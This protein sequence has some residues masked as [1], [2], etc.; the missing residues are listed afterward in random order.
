MLKDV[1]VEFFL[2]FSHLLKHH[3]SEYVISIQGIFERFFTG[4]HFMP[5]RQEPCVNGD[6]RPI[7]EETIQKAGLGW[8]LFMMYNVSACAKVFMF[9]YKRSFNQKT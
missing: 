1:K 7:Y 2:F 6:I 8:R 5:R 4:R 3:V 9:L